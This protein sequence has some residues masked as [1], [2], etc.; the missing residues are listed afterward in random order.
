MGR[1]AVALVL[2]A[3]AAP[4]EASALTY[5][6][7]TGALSGSNAFIG[8]AKREE[9]FR[10]YVSDATAE[11]ATLSVWFRGDVSPD[12][13]LTASAYGVALDAQLQQREASG[14]V[15]L[16]DGRTL[17][18]AADSGFGGGLVDRSFR[19]ARASYRSGWI[20]LRD[21]RVRGRTTVAGTAFDGT[22]VTGPGIRPNPTCDELR[23]D[24]EALGDQRGRLLHQSGVW[25][26]RLNR[27]RGSSA[28]YRRLTQAIGALDEQVFSMERYAAVACS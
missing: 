17:Q 8:I 24:Y 3:L 16:P 15:T 6:Q 23:E 21:K 12:G 14:T 4:A 1:L 10:A 5:R 20:V 27:G 25:E 28:A 7:Y 11:G 13:H 22:A 18:F 19:H 2:V 9:R 26:L